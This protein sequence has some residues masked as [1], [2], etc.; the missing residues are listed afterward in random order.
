VRGNVKWLK[1]SQTILRFGQKLKQ[2]REENLRFIRQLIRMPLHLNATRQ[3]AV[4]GAKKP[5]L[6]RNDEK[7]TRQKENDPCTE[8][9]SRHGET[10]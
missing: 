4:L 5:Q 7:I 6:K 9:N 8:E 10:F 2:K 1:T 3:W